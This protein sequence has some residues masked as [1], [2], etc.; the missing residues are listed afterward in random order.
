MTLLGAA[1]L[2]TAQAQDEKG[3]GGGPA[4]EGKGGQQQG[5]RAG[6]SEGQKQQPGAGQRDKGQRDSGQGQ[7]DSSPKAAQPQQQRDSDRAKATQQQDND[8]P[9]S[10]QQPRQ[11]KDRPKATEQQDKDRPKS[12]QQPQQDKD[13]PKSTQQQEDKDRSKST[14]QQQ[15]RDKDRQK[16][17]QPPRG[18]DKSKAAE[19]GDKR[20][21]QVSDDNRRGAGKRIREA[22]VDRVNRTRINV[23]VRIGGT[24]PRSIRLHTVPVFVYDEAPAYRGYSYVLLDDDTILI[25]DARTYE[26]IDVIPSGSLRADGPRRHLALSDDQMRFVFSTVSRDRMS[27]VR[28]RLALGAEVPRGIELITF[29]EMVTARIGELESYRYI[30]TDDGVVVVDP[31]DH[32]VVLVISN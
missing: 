2:A 11:D 18:D 20:R 10:T 30:V 19:G 12:A 8:R 4:A 15:D 1:V 6:D 14:R 13:R 32:S 5:P 23:N 31:N 9:K 24:L 26:I 16:S 7:R 17:A 29:P 28:V 27:D 21:V 3:K 22:K 25:V